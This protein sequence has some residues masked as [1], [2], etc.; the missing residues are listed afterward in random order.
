MFYSINRT[1]E[2][3]HPMSWRRPSHHVSSPPSSSVSPLNPSSISSNTHDEKIPAVA[4][5]GSGFTLRA[6]SFS[7]RQVSEF[8]S[9]CSERSE[10]N[11]LSSVQMLSSPIRSHIF[12]YSTRFS[13]I[14]FLFFFRT[15]FFFFA[16]KFLNLSAEVLHFFSVHVGD[17][18][19]EDFFSINSLLGEFVFLIRSV[20]LGFGG[21]LQV[22]EATSEFVVFIEFDFSFSSSGLVV[23]FLLQPALSLIHSS[24]TYSKAFRSFFCAVSIAVPFPSSEQIEIFCFLLN[25]KACR[26]CCSELLILVRR[27]VFLKLSP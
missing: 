16:W 25:S 3:A 4:L 10:P 13:F 6:G 11:L 17:E 5:F 22:D 18:R 27:V 2:F 1:R 21:S 19:P 7:F 20:L 26:G 9:F 14:I 15:F 23:L 8:S 12:E 24:F